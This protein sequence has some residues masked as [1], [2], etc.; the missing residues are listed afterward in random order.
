MSDRATDFDVLIVGAGISGI[1]MAA[2]MTAKSPNRSYAILERR[3][4]LGGTWDLFRYPGIRSDSD[5][6]TLGFDF[7]PWK[8]E[9]SIADGPAILDYLEKI[10]D[11]RGIRKHIRF[12]HKVIAADW[13]GADA[14]WHVTVEGEDGERKHLTANWLYLGSGYYDYDEPYDPGFDFGEFEGQVIHPQFWPEDLDYTGKQVVVIGSGA[15]AVTIVPSMADKAAKVTM[16]QRTPTW[17]F[18]RPAK[19]ALA[20]FL[21][22]VLPEETAYRI[23]RWKNI[24]MQDFSFKM[25][26]NKPQKVKDGLHKR[27]RK[28]MGKDYDLTPFTPPYD[29]WD[30]RLCLVP[31]DDLFEALKSGKADVV[32]GHIKAFEKGGVRL[33]DDTFLPADIVVT[34]TGLKL[35]VAGKIDLSLEGEKVDLADHFYYKGC[36]FSNVPNLAVVFGYLNA[37]WTLRADIN[38]DY[39]CRVL[40][41]MD[42]VGVDVAVPVLPEN[43]DLEE[44]DI[45]DFSSGYIQRGKAIM[46]KNAVGYPWR[47]NQEYVQDRKRMREEPIDDGILA[48]RRKGANSK[49]PDETLEAAE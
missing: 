8:H 15:T 42:A 35:A 23:T 13:R 28:S 33:Q 20:N 19:D 40:N 22:K 7:E 44:D 21:R 46:P 32:T 34:A 26:R 29:P 27:I 2:H 10:A 39:I 49:S 37:S 1:G 5:M 17:M 11:E 25:A 41:E 31:D 12:G 3:E 30:Q 16:L 14:R 18:S 36:M 45:F 48:F 4:N 6:H 24:K 9:K 43:H 38:S 47:L